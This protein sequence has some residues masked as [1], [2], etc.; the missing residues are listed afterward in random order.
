[1]KRG[2][3]IVIVVLVILV[4]C[5][6]SF[7]LFVG[8]RK[9]YIAEYVD[10]TS[11]Q[12]S[13]DVAIN[14]TPVI[15]NNLILGG[16]YEKAWVNAER[17]YLK[18]KNKT[19]DIDIYNKKGKAGKFELKEIYK[20]SS[21]AGTFARTSNTSMTEEYFAIAADNKDV[22]PVPATKVKDINEK[23]V[24][25]VKKALGL[26]KIFNSTVKITEIYQASIDNTGLSTFIFVTSEPTKSAGAYSAIIYINPTGKPKCI[27][28]NYIKNIKDASN[29]PIYSFEF[30]ADINKD[31]KNELI[32]Q[33]TKE[34]EVKYDIL[35]QK[36]NNFVE[37]LSNTMK[38]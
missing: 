14:S 2:L 17:Y 5:S 35:E 7:L 33:E 8:F 16:V 20:D 27:K 36:D 25:N 37:I 9:N 1:M 6:S 12:V 29:F 21:S 31:G 13:D 38:T 24:K 34:F 26:K 32:I 15:I 23:D 3:K 10:E 11:K 22:M 30:V 4:I 19:G 28:Y 18:S